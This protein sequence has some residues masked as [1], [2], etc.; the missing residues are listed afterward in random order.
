MRNHLPPPPPG[1]ELTGKSSGGK[2]K[3]RCTKR[4]RNDIQCT[5]EIRF[6]STPP[7]HRCNFHQQHVSQQ[8]QLTIDAWT[9]L[10]APERLK[11]EVASLVAITHVPLDIVENPSFTRILMAFIDIGRSDPHHQI[12][13]EECKL[14]RFNVRQN[15]I[16]S[17]KK[18]HD[19]QLAQFAEMP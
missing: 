13:S 9:S 17:A 6:T 5:R 3:I 4:D 1:W 14:T 19:T 10:P 8:T 16:E 2:R 7:I 18:F 12:D 15:I 11:H